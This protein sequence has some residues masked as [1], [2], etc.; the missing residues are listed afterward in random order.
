MRKKALNMALTLLAGFASLFVLTACN[1]WAHQ[2]EV[3]KELLKK[4]AA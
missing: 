4:D 3:P 1:Y 2:P